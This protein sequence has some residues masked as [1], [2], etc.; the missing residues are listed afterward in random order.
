MKSNKARISQP[1]FT[2]DDYNNNIV[3]KHNNRKVVQLRTVSQNQ[4]STIDKL[5][6]NSSEAADLHT[7]SLPLITSKSIN[8]N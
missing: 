3:N 4:Q 2:N 1:I 8:N 6:L 7:L 5:N